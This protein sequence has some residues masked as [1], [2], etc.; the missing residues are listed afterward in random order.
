MIISVGYIRGSG[1]AGYETCRGL[2][3]PASGGEE[4]RYHIHHT[5]RYVGHYRCPDRGCQRPA[6]ILEQ[7]EARADKP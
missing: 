2:R 3:V 5:R 6:H 1:T 4:E 7:N